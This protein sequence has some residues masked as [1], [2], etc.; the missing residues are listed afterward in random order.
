MLV[1]IVALLVVVPLAELTVMIAV[2]QW[3]GVWEAIAL[4][5]AVSLVGA[6]LVK[7][8]GVG[9]WRRIRSEVR[10]GQVPAAAVLDGALVLF[11]GVLLIIPGFLT[12]LVGLC[13]LVPPVR[14]LIR[15]FAGRR[16]TRRVRYIDAVSSE[17]RPQPPR[18][19]P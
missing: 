19:N 10:S 3:I 15:R 9:A 17:M 2:G 14:D 12:D 8:Q 4:L 11:A 16:I 1:V 7:R 6:V 18:L 5:L 13:L